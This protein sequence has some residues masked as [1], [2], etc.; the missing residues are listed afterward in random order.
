MYNT[1]TLSMATFNNYN[2]CLCTLTTLNTATT[3][4]EYLNNFLMKFKVLFYQT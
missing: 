2:Y 1:I 3:Q 4:L